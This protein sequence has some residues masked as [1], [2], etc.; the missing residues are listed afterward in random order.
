[1][2]IPQQEVT[3]AEGNAL[4]NEFRIRFFETS[5]KFG[6]NVDSAFMSI[7]VECLKKQ[8][9]FPSGEQLFPAPPPVRG[10]PTPA[11]ASSLVQPSRVPA[12]GHEGCLRLLIAAGADLQQQNK[13]GERMRIFVCVCERECE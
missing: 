10:Q 2:F 9:P 5:A 12:R 1:M 7:A 4:A 8:R 3:T 11:P 6:V 13:V